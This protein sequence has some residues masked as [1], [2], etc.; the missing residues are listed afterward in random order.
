[1]KQQV[2]ILSGIIH[3][4][5]DEVKFYKM[6]GLLNDETRLIE[7]V[8]LVSDTYQ[9]LEQ[10]KEIIKQLNPISAPV[11]IGFINQQIN[12]YTLDMSSGIVGYTSLK[13]AIDSKN[14]GGH[15]H[16]EEIFTGRKMASQFKSLSPIEYTQ[17]EE[18]QLLL[19]RILNPQ[20]KNF[21]WNRLKEDITKKQKNQKVKILSA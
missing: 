7:G 4:Y 20:T 17:D 16:Q 2:V 11:T 19:E 21:M 15:E 12:Y 14:N 13:L 6:I 1:M 5:F 18:L 8:E 3:D 9:T 10:E